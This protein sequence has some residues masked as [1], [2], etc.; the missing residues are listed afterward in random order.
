MA[1][2]FLASDIIERVRVRCDLPVFSSETK[3]TTAAI[4]SIVQESARELSALLNERDWYFVSTAPLATVAGQA[5]V[6]LPTNFA[7][8][9]RLAW[10]KTPREVIALEAANLE[11]VRPT[12]IQDTWKT[13]VPEY[14]LTGNTLEFFPTPDAI[15]T[16]ELRYSTGA[17]LATSGDTLFGQIGWDTWCVYN[18]CCVVCQAHDRDYAR[19]SDERDRK[20]VDIL[21]TSK[22]DKSGISQPRDVRDSSY[23]DPVGAWWRL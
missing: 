4:L 22:R 15:Y 11:Q 1:V 14:R 3:I 17:F 8:L 12:Q 18:A 6:S 10:Q 13:H 23:A 5:Y 20:L 2:G 21:R 7:A 16:L 19:F 9:L